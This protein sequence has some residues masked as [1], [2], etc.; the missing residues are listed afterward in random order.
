MKTTGNDWVVANLDVVGYY[1]VNYDQDNWDRLLNCLSTDHKV[2]H[3]C[4]IH[5]G[6]MILSHH[7]F[8]KYYEAA[9]F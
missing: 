9:S 5:D 3:I 7:I 6:I 1:R 4:M 8:Y 2:R